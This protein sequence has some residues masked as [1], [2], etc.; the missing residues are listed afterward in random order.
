MDA[1]L[2]LFLAVVALCLAASAAACASPASGPLAAGDASSTAAASPTV[3][4]TAPQSVDGLGAIASADPVVV[5]RPG[6]DWP[7]FGYDDANSLHVVDG[8]GIDL[9][10]AADLVT[11][12]EF[13]T[14][15]GVTATPAV[16]DGV[17]Y[18]GDWSGVL[19]AVRL[20][21]GTGIWETTLSDALGG[22]PEVITATALVTD[23]RVF[24][25][26]L[27]GKLHAV[28]RE[29]GAP[30]WS[31]ALEGDLPTAAIFSSPVEADGRLIL[32]TVS[33]PPDRSGAL[34]FRGS[35]VGLDAGT[36]RELWRVPIG[37]SEEGSGTAIGVWSSAAV[38][39]A[40]H[41]AYIGTGNTNRGDPLASRANALLAIDY[42]SGEIV[43][44]YRFVEDQVDN[45]VD[46]GA[47]PN[48]LTVD[49]RDAVGVGCKNGEYALLD[50][51]TG[52]LIWRTRLTAGG[53]AGG[54][55]APAVLGDGLIYV[56]SYAWEPDPDPSHEIVFALDASNGAIRW[57]HAW[58]DPDWAA[59][60]AAFSNDVLFQA[61]TYALTALDATNGT[62]LWSHDVPG[63]IGGG[64]SIASGHVLVGYNAGWDMEVGQRQPAGLL[65][66]TLSG[67]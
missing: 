44:Q 49:G 56:H 5:I 65:A 31:V 58:E 61:T 47:A 2:R 41:I 36:G 12:W 67:S 52:E 11:A 9:D 4:P 33:M 60:G 40:R 30:V 26:D 14:E 19:H 20:N 6:I 45:D 28:D 17:V 42:E 15:G 13:P 1:L 48:L 38:D 51:N 10:T 23:R 53:P 59:P 62:V 25:P 16:V 64:V 37:S 55:M 35:V 24:V 7:G 50:R 22:A 21:D 18:F 29:T 46:V 54:V 3:E 57:Q 27:G 32:G 66:F 63:E 43:W 34:G 39:R 8:G